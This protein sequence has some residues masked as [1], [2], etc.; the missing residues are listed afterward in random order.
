M[1]P[2]ARTSTPPLDANDL[3]ESMESRFE[4]VEK[5]FREFGQE[6][7]LRF[8]DRL[9]T[10]GR[11]GLLAQAERLGAGLGRWTEAWRSS[12]ERAAGTPAGIEPLEGAI[13]LPSRGEAPG[14]DRKSAREAG[15]ELLRTGRVAILV[16]AGGQATR[17]GFDAPKG[18]F[19]LGPV[20]DRSLFE[21]QAQKLRGLARRYGRS[22][23]WYVM[24][25]AATEAPTRAL[26]E[27][28]DWWGLEPEA[29]HLFSQEMVPAF[30]ANGHAVLETMGRIF[31]SPDGHGG[32]IPALARS[33]ALSQMEARGIDTVFYYQVDNPL[34]RMAD[35]VFLGFH[36]DRGAEVSCKVVRKR[37]PM[38]KWGVVA[39]VAGRPGVV[40][41]TELGD[42]E[43]HARDDSGELIYW[44][45]NIAIHVFDTAF[46]RRMADNADRFLPYHLSPKKVPT[47]DDSGVPLAP[48]GPNAEKLERFVFDALP[49]AERVCVVE[50]DAALEFSPV[51]NA[52]GDES[53]QTARRDLMAVYRSWL[54]AAGLGDAVEGQQVEID[55][56]AVDGPEE[57]LA[58]GARQLE[59]AR[60]WLH[61][62]TE[63]RE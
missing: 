43:R 32:V 49:E 27:A 34:V 53:P 55:H 35:P 31:E 33:G 2:Q 11:E 21:L 18:A 52:E 20:S 54:D 56:S 47:V 60:D 14:A 57:A 25:S 13:A 39:H 16:V 40:E 8:W 7:V 45:G 17:L 37:D 59:E 12:H 22:L 38:A 61:C 63:E 46:L 4:A 5:Q 50:A 42:A 51:K 15:E 6:H 1:P 48:A 19:P 26:F 23:P 36:R 9:D 10:P 58:M 24:T 29:V 62:A 41:Y 28:N 30:D 44:A 3:H